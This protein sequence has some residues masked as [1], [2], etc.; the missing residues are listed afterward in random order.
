MKG[1]RVALPFS[2]VLQDNMPEGVK[3]ICLIPCHFLAGVM[4]L[5]LGNQQFA[6]QVILK[7]FICLPNN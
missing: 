1:S 7:S 5:C 4:V 6:P 2:Q 3:I